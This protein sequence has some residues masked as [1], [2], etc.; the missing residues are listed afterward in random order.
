MSEVCQTTPNEGKLFYGWKSFFIYFLQEVHST[1]ETE[2]YWHSE[3]GYSTIFTTF[4]SSRAG[5]T[6]MFTNNFQFQILKLFTDPKGRFIIADIET[7]HT[8]M[9][10]FPYQQFSLP[11]DY[12]S[13]NITWF[14]N[15]PL[16]DYNSHYHSY[17]SQRARHISQLKRNMLPWYEKLSLIC[18]KAMKVRMK[19]RCRRD[20]N[21]E[22]YQSGIKICS[23]NLCHSKQAASQA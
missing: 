6:I 4:S 9:T 17:Q 13:Q 21:M 16:N 8:V 20:S 2:S 12:G 22:R 23:Y 15:W 11:R 7:E 14:P 19:Y 3:W 18:P 10:L 1:S 5:I